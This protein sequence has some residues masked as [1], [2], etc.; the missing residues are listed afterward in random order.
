LPAL[1]LTGSPSLSNNSNFNLETNTE[2]NKNK[3]RVLYNFLLR[4]ESGV[5]INLWDSSTALSL[6]QSFCQ[7]CLI[8]SSGCFYVSFHST[9]Q[10]VLTL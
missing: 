5:T 2:T 3:Y 4:N 10:S 8:E 9:F 1:A 6:I 7:V